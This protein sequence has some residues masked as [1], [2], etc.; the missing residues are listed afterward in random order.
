MRIK[1]ESA[2][3]VLHSRNALH[4]LV[5]IVVRQL[6][7]AP[8]TPLLVDGHVV[9]A[10]DGTVLVAILKLRSKVVNITYTQDGK[11]IMLKRNLQEEE[12]A[13]NHC[14][15]ERNSSCQSLKRNLK[16][17]RSR[18]FSLSSCKNYTHCCIYEIIFRCEIF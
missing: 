6:S 7:G 8:I 2:L 4:E 1:W 5:G 14:L 12:K 9:V 3:L 10:V 15:L 18:M 11:T 16:N 17:T 13:S